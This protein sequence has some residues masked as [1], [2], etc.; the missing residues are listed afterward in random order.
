MSTMT[1]PQSQICKALSS[2]PTLCF[3]TY[4]REPPAELLRSQSQ[5]QSQS[6]IQSQSH[7][8]QSQSQSQIQ[9]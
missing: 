8:S 7:R 3:A 2:T 5:S 4:I 1:H 6:Q 9:V